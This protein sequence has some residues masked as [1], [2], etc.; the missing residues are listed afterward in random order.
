M[1]GFGT[2]R[3]RMCCDR[4]GV[5]S[6]D[7]LVALPHQPLDLGR[8]APLGVGRI[9]VAAVDTLLAESGALPDQVVDGALQLGDAILEIANGRAGIHG[10]SRVE[11]NIARRGLARH[12]GGCWSWHAGI[13]GRNNIN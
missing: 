9:G 3:S 8:L 2:G 5:T 12:W 10:S 6:I 7:V 1:R 13:R 4:P 11:G